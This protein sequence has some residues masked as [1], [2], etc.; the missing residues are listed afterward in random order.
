MVAAAQMPTIGDYITANPNAPPADM[1]AV[2]MAET[3]RLKEENAWIQQEYRQTTEV[4]LDDSLNFKP[5]TMAQ[6]QRLARMYAESGLVPDHYKNNVAGCA[7]GIQM[8]L[9]MHVDILTFLQCSFVHKGKIG[10]EAKLA[11]ARLNTSGKIKGRVTYKLDRGPDGK[12][13]SCTATAEDADS[14]EIFSQT[15]D[16]DMV[17]AEGW[18]QSNGSQ[19]S[20]WMT[21]PDLM[22]QYRAGIFLA[23]IHYPDVLLG[24]YTIDELEDMARSGDS[25]PPAAGAPTSALAELSERMGAS[26]K[27]KESGKKQPVKSESVE[28]PAQNL[29]SGPNLDNDPFAPNEDRKP[30]T[31]APAKP[32]APSESKQ[33]TK[34]EEPK[35]PAAASSTA[36]NSPPEPTKQPTKEPRPNAAQLKGFIDLTYTDADLADFDVERIIAACVGIADFKRLVDS[37]LARK[38][39]QHGDYLK[40]ELRSEPNDF[41]PDNEPVTEEPEI[42]GDDDV[43]QETPESS[44]DVEVETGEDNQ[45]IPEFIRAPVKRP[46]LGIMATEAESTIIGKRSPEMIRHYLAFEVDGENHPH[47]EKPEQAYLR[48]LG[49]RRA[50]QLE[51]NLPTTDR[52]PK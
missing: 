20:K 27:P 52:L 38:H 17:V 18:N 4:E 49:N 33:A 12:V 36:K 3:Q 1:L 7:I 25:G 28:A 50:Y 39:P 42:E 15:V 14:G 44:E 30:A 5:K 24:M 48:S 11:M 2:V 9:R 32:S 29:P 16:W 26:L 35:K 6:L 46:K 43:S 34:V 8:A 19:K 13:K 51:H 23:R 47:L 31:K 10:I 41:V 45:D 37:I 40:A 21:L 22:F